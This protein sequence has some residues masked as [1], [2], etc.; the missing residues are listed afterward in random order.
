MKICHFCGNIHFKE[1]HVQYIYRHDGQFLIVNNVPCVECEFCGEQYFEARILKKIEQDFQE[2]HIQ[3]K[4]AE[5]EILV[6]YEDF[7]FA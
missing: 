2:I 7:V 6:P 3:G 1:T 4:K 5:H